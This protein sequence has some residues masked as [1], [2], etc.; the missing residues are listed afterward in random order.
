MTGEVQRGKIARPQK[1]SGF[2]DRKNPVDQ[3]DAFMK[4]ALPALNIDQADN[5]TPR[6]SD[7]QK[8]EYRDLRKFLFHEL[9][10]T[11]LR[12]ELQQVLNEVG[13]SA[14]WVRNHLLAIGT[15]SERVQQAVRDGLSLRN[16]AVVARIRRRFERD[17]RSRRRR[18]QWGKDHVS[19]EASASMDSW[20]SQID[21]LIDEYEAAALQ[22]FY[23]A[24]N[25]R[26]GAS[27]SDTVVA[28]EIRH[29]VESTLIQRLPHARARSEQESSSKRAQDEGDQFP[30][31]KLVSVRKRER[32]APME[33][34]TGPGVKS[35]KRLLWMYPPPSP[36]DVRREI[37]PALVARSL[38]AAYMPRS[39]GFVID[40]MAGS[41][42]TV[43]MALQYKHNIWAGDL[44][45]TMSL[46]EQYD[47][48]DKRLLP[49]KDKPRADLLILH[50]PTY[51]KWKC[52][53][54]SRSSPRTYLLFLQLL[55]AT[56][57]KLVLP[58]GYVALILQP[59]PDQRGDV[60]GG[61]T[62]GPPSSRPYTVGLHIAAA[63]DGS[64]A[65]V[66][67]VFSDVLMSDDQSS[68]ESQLPVSTDNTEGIS[69]DAVG[70][71]H[72]KVGNGS[73]QRPEG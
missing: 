51:S 44:H 25:G 54:G 38:L 41:G 56:H 9:G 32:R 73:R 28:A 63:R 33:T 45:P 61:V 59:F 19:L 42:V 64:Q 34:A 2:A 30:P 43:R 58:G 1:T 72:R 15:W 23:N 6:I 48:T 24:R 29:A 12:P 68:V 46:I 18:M 4:L 14:S 67:L 20:E 35:L 27:V 8:K 21:D 50:P 65:W 52:T 49:F 17:V 10:Q 7:A 22:P 37:L 69:A 66:L 36:E 70:S 26:V 55:M 11:R 53:A 3:Y 31:G 40:P 62:I 13:L 47:V 57:E 16:G 5:P 71:P 39:G 60:R